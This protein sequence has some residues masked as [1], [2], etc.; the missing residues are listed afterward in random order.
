M[1]TQKMPAKFGRYR[2]LLAIVTP[3]RPLNKLPCRATPLRIYRSIFAGFLEDPSPPGK[4]EKVAGGRMRGL[5][6][7]SFAIKQLTALRAGAGSV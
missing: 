7:V 1:N 5:F 4:G 6:A 3:K 2:E